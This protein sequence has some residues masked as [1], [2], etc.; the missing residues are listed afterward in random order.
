MGSVEFAVEQFNVPLVV[1]LGH[2][3]C[4]AIDATMAQIKSTELDPTGH[5][6]AIVDRIAPGIQD[7]MESAENLEDDDL[8]HRCMRANVRAS[9]NQLKHGSRLL[10]T[11]LASN[12]LMVL[13]AEYELATGEVALI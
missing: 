9:V 13:G 7:L 4:G 2:S 12:S 6:G 3:N 1:V 10:E 5:L 11:R 8:V